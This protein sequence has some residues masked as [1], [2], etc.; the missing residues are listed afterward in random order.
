MNKKGITFFLK[1]ISFSKGV[2]GIGAILLFLNSCI[3]IEKYNQQ[4]G[5]LHSSESLHKDVDYVYKKLQN[6]HPRL[7]QFVSKEVL[8][9]KFD[10]LKKT[11]DQPIGS[12]EFYYKLS[13]I[14]AEIHQGH[15]AMGYPQKRYTR[16]ERKALKKLKLGFSDL[17]FEHLENKLW[18]SNVMGAD[19]ILVGSEVL[20]VNEEPAG[21]ILDRYKKT[22]SSDGYNTT[23]QDK[24]MAL[25]FAGLYRKHEGYLD[26]VSLTLKLHDSVFVKNYKRFLKDSS[27]LKKVEKVAEDTLIPKVVKLTKAERSDL[28]SKKRQQKKDHKK[29]GYRADRNFN[30]R[31]FKFM[32]SSKQIGYMKIRN[33][34]NGPY[35]KFY[36]ESFAA[37]DSLKTK[38]LILDLRDNT[39][40]RLDEIQKFYSYLVDEE[41]R[42]VEKAETK[43]R[44]P[45]IKDY[46]GKNS[47]VFSIVG[48]TVVIP[49]LFTWNL[50][51]SHKKNGVVYYNYKPAKKKKPSPLNFKGEMYVLING[52]SFSASSIISTNLKATK[53]AVFVGEETG[54]A[55]NG[56]VAG[57]YKTVYAPN[58]K[59]G[60]RFGLMHIQSPYEEELIGY[61]IRPDVQ[62]TPTEAD[63][64]NGVDPEMEWVLEDIKAKQGN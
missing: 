19:S 36:E 58:S 29:Y 17:D 63:R 22:F 61:G 45:Y 28:K 27:K 60:L 10:S 48:E 15:I 33:W 7:Y 38:F 39:G 51:N 37:M 46:Y 18:V 31:N 3:S 8:D 41:F 20:S 35:K 11:I 59:V 62:I 21:S 54:G 43:T 40:G 14:V 57:F 56:T 52:N 13:P 9:R 49:F 24:Y 16:K 30:T 42:F 1:S 26:S 23:F 53:R 6:L 4:I 5:E 44:L 12:E 64:K 32:D 47:N 34:S 2:M 55:F 25:R 50:L